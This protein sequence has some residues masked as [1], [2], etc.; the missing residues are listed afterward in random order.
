[1]RARPSTAV[2]AVEL[3]DALPGLAQLLALLLDQFLQLVDLTRDALEEVVDLVD[4]VS[5]NPDFEG[6][7]VDGVESCERGYPCYP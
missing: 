3:V 1:M 7:R 2:A 6:H 4:V 5:P